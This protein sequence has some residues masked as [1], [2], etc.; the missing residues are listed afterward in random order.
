LEADK[1][2]SE[3]NHRFAGM[4]VIFAGLLGLSEP[5][6]ARRFPSFGYLWAAFFFIPG[7]YLFLWS[8]PESWPVGNQTLWHVITV[9]H[10]VLQHKI[11]SFIL[12][13][14]GIVEFQRVRKRLQ[15]FWAVSLFPALAAAGAV[16]LLFHSHPM[17]PGT[18]MSAAEHLSMEKVEHQHFSFASVGFGIALSKAAVDSGR[19][20]VRVMRNIHALLMVSLG[21][22]LMLYTE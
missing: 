22:L 2:F 4:F 5:L 8:D 15:S 12:L 3:F 21:I 20:N 1:R 18:S 10:Q 7:V 16:L 14:L 9:N 6:I 19:F 17:P 13:V 11:F